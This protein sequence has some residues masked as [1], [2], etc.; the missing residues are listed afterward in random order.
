MEPNSESN[1]QKTFDTVATHLLK[2]GKRAMRVSGTCL[3]RTPDGLKCAVG[4]L[5]PEEMYSP[6]M[7]ENVVTSLLEK[8]PKLHDVPLINGFSKLLRE[9]QGLHDGWDVR[10]WPQGLRE[11]AARFGLNT[12]AITS[13]PQPD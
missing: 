7:E 2:Q 5:I 11:I 1:M 9:L 8:F 4:C 3:Y 12:A 13:G 10:D 6:D